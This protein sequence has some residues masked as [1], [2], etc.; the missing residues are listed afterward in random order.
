MLVD[1]GAGRTLIS[2]TLFL[3]LAG[4]SK[5]QV[6]RVQLTL[7]DGSPLRVLGEVRLRIRLRSEN[8]PINAVV[9]EGLQYPSLMGADFIQSY[10]FVIDLRRKSLFCEDR[11]IDVPLVT[12][13]NWADDEE[14]CAYVIEKVSIEP[15]SAATVLCMMNQKYSGDAL[16]ESSLK[17]EE[18]GGLV[19]RCLVTDVAWE[20]KPPMQ[21][22]LFRGRNQNSQQ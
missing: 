2:N 22:Y 18:V 4:H 1:T 11:R 13:D 6:S 15:K 7:A 17:L 14:A 3:K 20:D 9:V 10:G 19:P 21:G 8:F 16:F 12:G 5:L